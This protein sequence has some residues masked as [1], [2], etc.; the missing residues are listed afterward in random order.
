[1]V[2]PRRELTYGSST[3]KNNIDAASDA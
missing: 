3:M 2:L 1:M